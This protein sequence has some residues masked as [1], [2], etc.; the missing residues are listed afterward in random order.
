MS[1]P[2]QDGPKR[3]ARAA[4][5]GPAPAKDPRPGGQARALHDSRPGTGTHADGPGPVQD[6]WLIEDGRVR[7]LEHHLARF[8]AGVRALRTHPGDPADEEL[9]AFLASLP[10]RFPSRGR[11]FPRIV[12]DWGA[13]ERLRWDLRPAPEATSGAVSLWSVPGPDPRRHPE[14]KGPDL[15]P[16][17]RLRAR[18][19]EHGA[20]EAV[21]LDAEG[22][23]LE[24][25]YSALVWWRD[26]ARGR[27]Y[28]GVPA[29]PVLPS[30]TRAL[31]EGF[32]V[33]DG[34]PVIHERVRPADLHGA[35][36]W[37]MSAL[38][39]LQTV[40][41]WVADAGTD[42]RAADQSEPVALAPD[43]SGR[44][45]TWQARL[46]ALARRPEHAAG[47]HRTR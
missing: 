27:L 10:A 41:G 25:A 9:A 42:G 37:C 29:G 19:Q 21:L 26:D 38:R 30:V 31:V 35:E 43:L 47:R 39:G 18:A 5:K 8:S 4:G 1:A 44:R 32:A 11:W 24:G 40:T 46:D 23:V 14:T 17:G 7:G 33:E 15:A 3:G 34:I 28:L 20:D 16:L 12:C 6:S 13:D 22:C 45:V 2:G 36:A